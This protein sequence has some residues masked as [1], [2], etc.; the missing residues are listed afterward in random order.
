VVVT[1]LG[2]PRSRYP[3]VRVIEAGRKVR[4]PTK[5]A[6]A[7]G[8]AEPVV[9]ELPDELETQTF[10]EIRDI[11]FGS[12]LITVLEILSPSNKKPGDPQEQYLRKQRELLQGGVSLV[13]ID[14][15]RE[16][17]WVLALPFDALEQ[18][19]QSLYR[20]VARRSWR[21]L[22]AEYYPINLANRLPRIKV[23]L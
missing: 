12:R 3:D 19:L 4:R 1:G 16:G 21:R 22:Q 2:R 6:M 15:L 5:S 14:L 10:V 13:E 23:P 11:A 8:V 17:D 20:V 7:M 9:I 18:E